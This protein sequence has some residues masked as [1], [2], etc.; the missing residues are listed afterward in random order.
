MQHTVVVSFVSDRARGVD[1]KRFANV[2]LRRR[3]GIFRT[4]AE[5]IKRNVRKKLPQTI[6]SNSSQKKRLAHRTL[7]VK[8]IHSL[9][10]K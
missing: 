4:E 1:A 3:T 5:C 6:N 9:E 8:P 10:R 7:R 2:I